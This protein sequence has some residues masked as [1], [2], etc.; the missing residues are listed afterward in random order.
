MKIILKTIPFVIVIGLILFLAI[1]GFDKLNG[2]KIFGFSIGFL[3]MIY[4]LFIVITEKYIDLK[5]GLK[6]KKIKE[7]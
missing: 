5:D 1:S 4:C 7:E 6:I 3:I 2:L